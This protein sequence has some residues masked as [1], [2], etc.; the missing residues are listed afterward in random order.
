MSFFL[1][2]QEI[3]EIMYN[4][5]KSYIWPQCFNFYEISRNTPIDINA[6]HK[7]PQPEEREKN[8]GNDSE[9]W[10]GNNKGDYSSI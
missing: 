5:P 2:L 7:L 3:H 10:K 9:E 8:K 6:A 1:S 4:H